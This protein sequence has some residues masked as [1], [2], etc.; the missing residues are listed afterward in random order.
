MNNPF[1]KLQPS[2]R[3]GSWWLVWPDGDVFDGPFANAATAR[4]YRVRA[5]E[6]ET[7][8]DV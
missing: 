7:H 6:S 8:K 3:S 5:I 1:E 4:A 2:E